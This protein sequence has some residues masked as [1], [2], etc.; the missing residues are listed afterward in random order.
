MNASVHIPL[1]PVDLEQTLLG[2][3]EVNEV[4]QEDFMFQQLA[5]TEE[6]MDI[7]APAGNEYVNSM[8]SI[9]YRNVGKKR[10]WN[11]FNAAKR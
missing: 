11:S 3:I 6:L 4:V 2:N 10:C 8:M 1:P 9:I 7:E 5:H